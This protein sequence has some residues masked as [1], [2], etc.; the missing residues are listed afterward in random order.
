MA[1]DSLGY[2]MIPRDAVLDQRLTEADR[3]V[4]FALYHKARN[5]QRI[6]A[7]GAFRL[8]KGSLAWLAKA[9]GVVETVIGQNRRAVKDAGKKTVRR[10]IKK[11]LVRHHLLKTTRNDRGVWEFRLP[12]IRRKGQSWVYSFDFLWERQDW[13]IWQKHAFLVILANYR[14]GGTDKRPHHAVIVR[15]DRRPGIMDLCYVRRHAGGGLAGDT[16]KATRMVKR[17]IDELIEDGVFRIVQRASQSEP[18]IVAVKKVALFAVARIL[19]AEK[20]AEA[21]EKTSKTAAE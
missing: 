1:N 9:A 17:F 15:G 12:A 11:L 2:V 6:E 21:P 20:S 13:Q 4:L 3:K 16:P 7:T 19:A 10:A 8:A 5:N 14:S 18:M